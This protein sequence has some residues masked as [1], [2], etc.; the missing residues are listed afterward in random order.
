LLA[1]LAAVLVAGLLASLAAVGVVV[2]SNL[3]SALRAE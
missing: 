3:L 2:R 1:L